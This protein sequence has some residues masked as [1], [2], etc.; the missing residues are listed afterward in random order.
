MRKGFSLVCALALCVLIGLPTVMADGGPFDSSA[1]RGWNEEEGYQYLQYGAY[2][3]EYADQPILWRVLT[4]KDG[5]MLLLSELILDAR[6]FD[7][8]EED[9]GR[10]NEWAE[11]ELYAWLNNEFIKEAFTQMDR[12]LI[13]D[14]GAAGKVFIPSDAEISTPAYG[15]GSVKYE[16]DPN[17]RATGTPYAFENGLWKSEG[18]SEY[19]T[20]YTRAKPNSK[21]VLHINTAGKA[22]LARVER[23]NVGVRPAM[24]LSV[25]FLPFTEGEGTL[26]DPFR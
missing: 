9:E 25:Q 15:F 2:P 8:R 17:R 18:G 20:Y 14:N 13:L 10:T 24:W 16:P 11:S 19:S 3:Q 4:V 22:G 12:G 6:P 26:E 23:T 21:N 5:R 1:L 7:G